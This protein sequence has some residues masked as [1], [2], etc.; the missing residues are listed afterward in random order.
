V[1]QALITGITGQDGGYLADQLT[2][3]GWSVHGVVRPGE[4]VPNHVPPTVTVHEAELLDSDRLESIISQVG[5]TEIYNLVGLSSVAL[6]WKDPVLTMRVN[7]EVVARLLE[8]VR[9]AGQDVRVLQ[10][11]SAE[12]FAGSGVV[13]QTESTP[14]VPTSPYGVS[15][16]SAHHLVTIYRA[17]GVHAVNAILYNHESPHRP[18]TFVTRKI[19][20][21][22]AAIADGRAGELVLG[23]LE[24]RRDWGWAPEYVDAMTR[25]VRFETAQDWVIATG[26][27]YSVRDFVKAAFSHVGIDDWEN[28][29]STDPAFVRPT[30][31]LDLV[32]DASKAQRL[33]GWSARVQLDELVGRMVDADRDGPDGLRPRVQ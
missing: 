3:Q 27:S 10:A 18:T 31:A 9:V 20:G 12:I 17:R 6:S 25:A 1:A 26:R 15:K 7:A 28:Y 2:A 14:V 16:A 4:D 29:V 13:P 5:P 30:D 8:A 23:S 19:T 33:L 11:S 32:G 21:T 24:A 22:V